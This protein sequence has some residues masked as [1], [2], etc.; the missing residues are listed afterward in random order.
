MS[1][2]TSFNPLSA[3]LNQNK[4]LGQQN[5]IDWKRNLDIVLTADGYKYVLT[6]PKPQEP[7]PDSSAEDKEKFEKWVKANDMA[8]C[9][10]LASVSNVIQP[11]HQFYTVA[12]DILFSIKEM[13]GTQ[14]RLE[15]QRAMRD[16]LKAKMSEGTPV[17]EHLLKMFDHLNTLEILGA[18]IDGESQ[19]DIILESLPESYDQFKLDYVLNHKDYTLSSLMAALQATRGLSS[20][21]HL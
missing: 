19:V 14:G 15:R 7:G 11:Q 18:E 17:Q 21:L 9:Y 1:S 6:D 2:H 3:I 16:F 4:L 10:I 20:P 5:F 12:S 13:F 8:K